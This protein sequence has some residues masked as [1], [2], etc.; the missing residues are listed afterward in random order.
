MYV[1]EIK[2][3]SIYNS[4]SHSILVKD[5]EEA[6]SKIKNKVISLIRD[7]RNECEY[8]LKLF[9]EDSK[10]FKFNAD[11]VES[12]QNKIEEVNRYEFTS[13]LKNFELMSCDVYVNKVEVI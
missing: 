9:K 5:D 4:E 10:D 7:D 2:A 3:T 11:W 1:W 13:Q 8:R 6:L 12:L